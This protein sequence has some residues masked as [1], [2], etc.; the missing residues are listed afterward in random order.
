MKLLVSC[1]D[2]EEARCAIR[3]GADI[4][5]VKNPNEERMGANFPGAISDV[6]QGLPTATV[7]VTLGAVPNLPGTV[8]LAALGAIKAGADFVK[9]GLLDARSREDAV[10]LLR[11]VKRAALESKVDV[12]AAAYADYRLFR[13]FDAHRV[14]E[15][16]RESGC[17]GILIDTRTK[18]HGNLFSYLSVHELREIVAR[19]HANGLIVALSGELTEKDLQAVR[20][21]G[22]DIVG[23]RGAVCSNRD[24]YGGRVEESAVARVKRCLAGVHVPA[25][26]PAA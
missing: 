18:G 13:G 15:V 9:V 7:S 24:R 17:A 11:E 2:V 4:V 26:A 19:A 10:C 1:Q 3:G 22:A 12:I 21:L 8:S 16:A 25:S 5:D 23:V 20:D 14:V 6:R